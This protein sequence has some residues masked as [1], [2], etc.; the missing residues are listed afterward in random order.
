MEP[1]IVTAATSQELSLLIQA[2]G[3]CRQE[4]CVPAEV[5]V[6]KI[7]TVSLLL[8]VT[9][10]GKVNAASAVT[11][12]LERHTPGLL[13]TT[14]CAGAYHGAGL[15]VGDLA[16]AVAE[17]FGDEGVLTPT[18]WESL[19]LIGIPAVV[20]NGKSYHNE[21]PLSLLAT[22]KAV[23]LAT[24]LGLAVRRGRFVT[25]STCSGTKARGDELASRFGAICENMEGAAVAQ[26]A[27][28]YGVDCLEVR[29]ISNMVE[30]RNLAAWDIPLAVAQ[31][32]RFIL[33]FIETL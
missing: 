19:Q 11:A 3:A 1:V 14:G 25:V 29:S 28:T 24:A 32:Q 18:G 31:S 4:S 17:I 5:Y 9:G 33:K 2:A 8:A 27:L 15:A 6:G 21:F 30:D 26:V 7:G 10:I 13:I 20:R 16:I 12:L 23:R 22:E